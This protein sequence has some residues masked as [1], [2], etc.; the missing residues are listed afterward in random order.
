MSATRAFIVRSFGFKEGINFDEVER[1]LIAPALAELEIEGRT[2]GEN[3]TTR[4]HS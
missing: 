2:T 3:H 1:L 4:E